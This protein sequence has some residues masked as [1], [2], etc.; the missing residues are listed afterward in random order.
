MELHTKA[1]LSQSGSRFLRE[2]VSACGFAARAACSQGAFRV[3]LPDLG[4]AT[5]QDVKQLWGK[6][7][8]QVAGPASQVVTDSYGKD[9][10][11][12]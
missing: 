4:E 5:L 1:V 2:L 3:Q 12:E 9:L 10:L 6:L 11:A 8:C 7:A